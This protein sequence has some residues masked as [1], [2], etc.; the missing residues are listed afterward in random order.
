MISCNNVKLKGEGPVVVVD[1]NPD[2]LRLAR[3]VF[4][5]SIIRNKLLLFESGAAL[6]MY[7]QGVKAGKSEPPS[8]VLLDINM[9]PPNGHETLQI[10]RAEEVFQSSPPI[11][12]LTASNDQSDLDRSK[13]AGAD[14]YQVK[15]FEVKDYIYFLNSLAP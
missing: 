2:S 4:E 3:F 15:P 13:E 1:D 14:G 6:L 7:L 9:P 10:I 11:V 12:M 5:Q 8:M